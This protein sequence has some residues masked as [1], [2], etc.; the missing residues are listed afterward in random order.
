[1]TVGPEK[2]ITYQC[3][4]CDNLS[5]HFECGEDWYRCYCRDQFIGCFHAGEDIWHDTHQNP[6]EFKCPEL[7]EV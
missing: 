6:S 3:N 4:K 1:M 2:I 7:K 5:R